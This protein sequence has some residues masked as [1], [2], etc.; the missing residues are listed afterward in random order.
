MLHTKVLDLITHG[1]LPNWPEPD[2]NF[3]P[4]HRASSE[5]AAARLLMEEYIKIGAAQ[6]VTSQDCPT[7]YL[8]PWFLIQKPGKNRL[9]ADCRVLNKFI[10]PPHFRLDNWKEIFPFLRK[11]MWGAKVDLQHAY[12]HLRN[13]PKLCPYMRINIEEDI[14]QLNAAVFGLNILPQLFMITMKVLQKEW[15]SQGLQVFVYLDDILI[16]GSTLSQTQK[17]LDIV[18]NTLDRAGFLINKKKSSEKPS[19][20]LE[21]L[22]FKIDF[23]QGHLLVPQE[24]L[25]LVKKE[26]GKLVTH[27]E[28]TPERWQQS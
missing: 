15:R 8:I 1:V 24:K 21:H 26:L 4:C 25:K 17:A 18:K 2:L 9:I 19:Q 7:R 23:Q 11:N 6:V 28:M 14:F 22:G 13:S 5:V 12:F 16:L 10:S 20:E 3:F 27:K